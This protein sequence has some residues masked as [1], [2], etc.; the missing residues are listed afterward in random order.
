M[1]SR[2]RLSFVSWLSLPRRSPSL[3]R[4]YQPPHRLNMVPAT[5][6]ICLCDG[7]DED[8]G[9]EPLVRDCSCR[10][11]SAG[12]A[13]KSCIIQYA[14]MKSKEDKDDFEQA[15]CVC[16]NCNQQYQN[17]LRLELS[18]E[19]VKFAEANHGN[20]GR[21]GV[22]KMIDV[23]KVM[24]AL[25]T[26]IQAMQDILTGK[27]KMN[28]KDV[29]SS[30]SGANDNEKKLALRI[31]CEQVVN[32]FL[33]L[34]LQAMKDEKMNGWIHLPSTSHE[35]QVFKEMREFEAFA[36]VVLGWLY[37]FDATKESFE[38]AIKHYERAQVIFKLIG[39]GCEVQLGYMAINIALT[40]EKQRGMGMAMP[41]GLVGAS[42]SLLQRNDMARLLKSSKGSYEQTI[43]L[44]G[45]NDE[46][47]IYEGIEYA[48]YLSKVGGLDNQPLQ[49]ATYHIEAERLITKLSASSHQVLGLEHDYTKKADDLMNHCK[50]RLVIMMPLGQQFQALR[51]EDD[52]DT[53]VVNGPIQYPRQVDDEREFH[54]TSDLVIPKKGCP[55][56]CHGLT[57]ATHL[58]GK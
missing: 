2:G 53:L 54:V 29:K 25:R 20:Q 34:T 1:K 24:V 18:G 50:E 13:H 16:P 12:Y 48:E 35:N 44:Y 4:Y 11:E 8:V 15:W 43:Q 22:R 19:L 36:L 52:G 7:G 45:N 40:R 23:S 31:E 46:R 28:V 37:D 14:T 56:V 49:N 5:C 27:N 33:S 26:N 3:L 30:A 9:E 58:N 51:Y 6:W 39:K 32:K 21:N 57:G 55:V 17:L 47:T 42:L 10:G 41:S 38:I